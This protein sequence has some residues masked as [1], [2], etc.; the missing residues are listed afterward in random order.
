MNCGANYF[1]D[2]MSFEDNL[3]D[4]EICFIE[5]GVFNGDWVE[6]FSDLENNQIACLLPNVFANIDFG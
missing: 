4:N 3:A 6:L 2:G 5:N 1:D